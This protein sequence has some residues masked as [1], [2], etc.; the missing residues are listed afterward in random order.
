M[1]RSVSNSMMPVPCRGS[2]QIVAQHETAEHSRIWRASYSKSSIQYSTVKQNHHAK[3]T[4]ISTPH[5]PALI[6]IGSPDHSKHQI[7]I[8]PSHSPSRTNTCILRTLGMPSE[9]PAV[10]AVSASSSRAEPNMV[11]WLTQCVLAVRAKRRSTP[12]SARDADHC[13]DCVRFPV[14]MGEEVIGYR[15]GKEFVVSGG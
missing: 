4:P 7:T 12:C 14:I 10:R 8:S 15:C 11:R 5:L 1:D 2:W 6:M 13:V 9:L 3:Q